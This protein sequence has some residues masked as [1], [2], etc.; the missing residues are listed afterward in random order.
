MCS[1][2]PIS[3]Y[4]LEISKSSAKPFLYQHFKWR[5][6]PGGGHDS[7]AI[8][9]GVAPGIAHWFI[10]G[11]CRSASLDAA[12]AS[13]S[14]FSAGA[15]QCIG[16]NV[17][18]SH[19]KMGESPLVWCGHSWY[20]YP[21]T[22]FRSFVFP[23]IDEKHASHHLCTLHTRE[24]PRVVYPSAKVI[25]FTSSSSVHSRSMKYWVSFG[26]W[27]RDFPFVSIDSD[28]LLFLRGFAFWISQCAASGWQSLSSV[29]MACINPFCCTVACARVVECAR[30]YAKVCL[31]N[32]VTRHVTST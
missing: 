8:W 27:T 32:R 6:R 4:M 7:I 15:L 18:L 31:L 20:H 1:S 14:G 11:S 25:S 30:A 5:T 28:H 16:R 26:I 12:S 22:S 13:G 29:R 24:A 21:Q 3:A 19:R 9:G 10:S 2:L 17:S 23:N